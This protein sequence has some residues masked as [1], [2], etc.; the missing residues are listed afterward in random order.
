MSL[1]LFEH[2]SAIIRSRHTT[3]AVMMNGQAI[4]DGQV[5][6][7]L[8]LADLAPNHGQTEPW[9]F[10]IFSGE[11]LKAFGKIH[12]GLYWSHTDAEKR[13]QAKYDKLLQSACN[14]S[15]LIIAVMKRSNNSKIPEW[16]ERLAVGAAIQNILLGATALN[17]SSFWST[18]GMTYHPELKRYLHLA[19]EDKVV[20][21][22]YLGYT[23][24]DPIKK[25][26]RNISIDKKVKWLKEAEDIT[27]YFD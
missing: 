6:E 23:N 26:R 14:A 12:A 18:G 24:N 17:I 16:E 2:I 11:A 27:G 22:L 8:E 7:L 19:E 10:F 5:G 13:K 9:R 4:P 25:R 3:K 15:H 20:G 21:L 1:D